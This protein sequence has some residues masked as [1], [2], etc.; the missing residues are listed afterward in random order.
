MK[1]I[2]YADE[3]HG[4]KKDSEV[5]IVAGLV[6]LRDEWNKFCVGWREVL[7][8]YTAPYFHFRE[9]ADA[10]AVVRGKRRASTEFTQKN[11]YRFW[12]QTKLDTFLLE[13]AE[14][15][16]SDN[17]VIIGGYVPTKKR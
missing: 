9:W 14:V 16:V 3:S 12:S 5:L 7:Y 17:K 10:S 15:A 6:G 8:R 2:A 13:L 4:G 11:P 1:L